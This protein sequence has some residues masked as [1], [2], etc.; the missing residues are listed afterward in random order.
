M[1]YRL[2]KTYSFAAEDRLRIDYQVTNLSPFPFAFLW[3]AH[4]LLRIEEGMQIIVSRRVERDCRLLF[5]T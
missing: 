2:E 5:G 4:P 1:P 3:A